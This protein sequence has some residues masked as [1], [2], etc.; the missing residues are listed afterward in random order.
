MLTFFTDPYEEEIMSSVIS[1]YNIYSG[2]LMIRNTAIDLFGEAGFNESKQ[3]PLKLSYLAKQ[4]EFTE[5]TAE[6]FIYK[7]TLF[8]LYSIFLN[9]K[10][11]ALFIKYLKG[12]NKTYGLSN[13]LN[14]EIPLKYCPICVEESI[15]KYGEAYYKRFHQIEG[16]NICNKHKCLL[17]KYTYQKTKSRNKLSIY[18][19]Q[20][21]LSMYS[22]YYDKFVDY[23]VF[24]IIDD[25]EYI[26]N[27]ELL[28]YSY[29]EIL[30]ELTVVLRRKK[31]FTRSGLRKKRLHKEIR[32]HYGMNLLKALEICK[33][34]NEEFLKDFTVDVY[35]EHVEPIKMI[36]LIKY[37]FGD[38]KKIFEKIDKRVKKNYI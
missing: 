18:L 25:I 38:I 33:D 1:R 8:P 26:L 34:E 19:E 23:K 15:K 37:L 35:N 12:E 13:I 28:K 29:E 31:Y 16:I 7:H 3:F 20:D 11:Q 30:R 36:L 21:K 10:N 2:N 6:Y 5:Y 27:L 17:Y 24:K 32:E 9:K 4:L 14:K 22:I